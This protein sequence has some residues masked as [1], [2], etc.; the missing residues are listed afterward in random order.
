MSNTQARLDTEQLREAGRKLKSMFENCGEAIQLVITA[1]VTGEPDEN[2]RPVFLKQILGVFQTQKGLMDGQQEN[3][4]TLS[5]LIE[6][7]IEDHGDISA[8][9]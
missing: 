7:Y 4:D 2:I 3:M 1:C 6:K 5:R 8:G 9:Y